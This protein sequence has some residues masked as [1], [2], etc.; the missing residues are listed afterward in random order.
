MLKIYEKLGASILI[1]DDIMIHMVGASRG[2]VEV[3]IDAPREVNIMRTDLVNEKLEAAGF[4]RVDLINWMKDGKT[5]LTL[6]ATQIA[7]RDEK[8]LKSKPED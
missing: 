6:E 1:G 8:W 4:K 3:L 7:Q 2:R 5:F